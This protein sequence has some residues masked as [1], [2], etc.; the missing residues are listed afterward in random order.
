MKEDMWFI[1]EAIERLELAVTLGNKEVRNSIEYILLIN[2]K[3]DFISK[4]KGG[5]DDVL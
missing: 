3:D 1:I 4:Y 5:H 2:Q